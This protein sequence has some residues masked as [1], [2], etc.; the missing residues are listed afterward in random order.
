M[1]LYKFINEDVINTD[2]ELKQISRKLKSFNYDSSDV[3]PRLNNT[4]KK[5][6]IEIRFTDSTK[7]SKTISVQTGI[8]SPDG[9]IT[10]YI[11][12]KIFIGE[13]L[14]NKNWKKDFVEHLE[15]IITHELT[16]REQFKRADSDYIKWYKENE[17]KEKE[18]SK[19]PTEL[20]AYANNIFYELLKNEKLTP[21]KFKEKIEKRN[22]D[23]WSKF[24][25]IFW[26]KICIRSKRSKIVLQISLHVFGQMIYR[27]KGKQKWED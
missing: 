15:S 18:I 16:H 5:D 14:A 13:V 17:P 4:L 26:F 21:E 9:D 6:R 1:R 2:A 25:N 12:P 22:E 20:M 10:I 8:T 27:N 19:N 24:R 7:W 3:F 11:N 23:K